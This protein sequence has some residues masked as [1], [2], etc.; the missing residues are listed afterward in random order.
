MTQRQL[1]ILAGVSTPTVSRFE[2]GSEDIQLSSATKVLEVLG[3][4]DKRTLTFHES[5]EKFNWDKSSVTFYGHDG[6]KK[7]VCYIP[8]EA[9][10]DTFR[11]TSSSG[12]MVIGLFRQNRSKIEHAARR[13]FFANQFEPDGSILIQY[14]DLQR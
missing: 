4:L 3:M 1:A 2:N 12:E 11:Q 5:W 6:Q 8:Q 7:I 10:D 13:K 9:L 14:Q